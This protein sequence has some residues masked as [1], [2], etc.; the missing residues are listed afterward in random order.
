MNNYNISDFIEE[1]CLGKGCFGSV[2]KM[3]Y[4]KD[5]LSYAV[6]IINKKVGKTIE[7]IRESKIPLYLSHGKIVHIYGGFEDNYNYYIVMEYISGKTLK[8]KIENDFQKS[9]F[10][11]KEDI[12]INIFEQILDGLRY[13][14]NNSIIHRDIKPDNILLDDKYNVKITDFGLSVLIRKNNVNDQN[15][16][17]VLFGGKTVVGP[18]HYID[19]EIIKGKKQDYKCDI[20]SLG[21]TIFYLMNLDLPHFDDD[22][23]R[24][25]KKYVSINE[26]YNQALRDLVNAMISEKPEDRPSANEALEILYSIKRKINNKINDKNIYDKNIYYFT[27]E[28]L[29]RKTD[30]SEVNKVKSKI[31]KKYYIIKVISKTNNEIDKEQLLKE[32][33]KQ[34]ELKNENICLYDSFED[35]RNYY[36]LMEYFKNGNLQTE[37]ENHIRKQNHIKQDKIISYFKQVINVL[38]YLYENNIIHRGIK[39]ENILVDDKEIIKLV[40]IGLSAVLKK[41]SKMNQE[42]NPNGKNK[43]VEEYNYSSPEILDGKPYDFKCDIYFL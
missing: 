42:P 37:V 23:F 41:S 10:G 39:P 34:S 3:K 18:K 28:K 12:I 43:N 22:N 36:F 14:H 26:H 38:L 15:I 35:N 11:I 25:Y 20:Y 33:A 2:L 7:F 1:K 21:V 6:K 9:P 8:E 31:N 40:D 24:R 17:P 16:D 32:I 19:P 29:L 30:Y 4:K 5:N 27:T 13:L